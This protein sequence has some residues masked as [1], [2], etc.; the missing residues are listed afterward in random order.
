[1]GLGV[2]RLT[3]PIETP[4]FLA[5]PQTCAGVVAGGFPPANVSLQQCCPTK[6]KPPPPF[7]RHGG[8][9]GGGGRS[10]RCQCRDAAPPPT[11]APNPTVSIHKNSVPFSSIFLF[12][13]VRQVEVSSCFPIDSFS[14]SIPNKSPSIDRSWLLAWCPITHGGEKGE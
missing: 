12:L 2:M 4:I 3:S 8:R 11:K 7:W 1:M 14:L 9:W 13:V 5:F 10:F 6:P